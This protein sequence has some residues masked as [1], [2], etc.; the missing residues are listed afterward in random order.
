FRKRQPTSDEPDRTALIGVVAAVFVVATVFLTNKKAA[1]TWSLSLVPRIAVTEVQVPRA[2]ES[3][4]V[5]HTTPH[6]EIFFRNGRGRGIAG[7][8]CA[9]APFFHRDTRRGPHTVTLGLK[10]FRTRRGRRP[11][12]KQAR[13]RRFQA[14][15]RDEILRRLLTDVANEPG[16]FLRSSWALA[17]NSSVA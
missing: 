10:P 9:R 13:R 1:A 5:G 6:V 11:A 12:V 15:C 14:W 7:I 16:S 8:N 4:N 3:V 2:F 17:A